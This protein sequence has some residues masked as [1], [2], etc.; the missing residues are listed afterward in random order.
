[1]RTNRFL[2]EFRR[3][4][5]VL[6]LMV[7]FGQFLSCY[8]PAMSHYRKGQMAEQNANN[9][10]AEEEYLAA[11]EESPGD[12]V[13][14]FALAKLYVNMEEHEKAVERFDEFLTLT[15][16]D[17]FKWK[18]ERWEADFYLE[19]SKQKKEKSSRKKK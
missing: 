2:R 17:D 12:P 4:S 18:D 15:A 3:H 19:K 14:V 13:V 1:M 6:V 7:F 9:V 11:L 16:D 10:K 5:S 8:S